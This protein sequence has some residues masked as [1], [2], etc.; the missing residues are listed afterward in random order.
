ML[1]STPRERLLDDVRAGLGE[2]AGRSPGQRLGIVG[3]C[4]GGTMTWTLLD[5]GEPSLAAAI[6]FYGTTPDPSDFSGCSAAVLGIYA[7][8][9]EK[10]NASR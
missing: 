10:V 1:S 4:F 9:D 7:G 8:L 2:L 3:F 6:A 5:A